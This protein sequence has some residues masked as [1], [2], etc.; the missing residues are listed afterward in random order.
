MLDLG[1]I[2]LT[3]RKN[4]IEHTSK[5]HASGGKIEVKGKRKP[6]QKIIVNGKMKDMLIMLDIN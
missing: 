4:I 2:I 3:I 6:K 5:K 1:K